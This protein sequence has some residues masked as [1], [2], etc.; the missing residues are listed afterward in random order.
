MPFSSEALREFEIWKRNASKEAIDHVY[1]LVRLIQRFD[2][3]PAE[4]WTVDEL[5]RF[6]LDS[7]AE[8][9][10]PAEDSAIAIKARCQLARGIRMSLRYT[11]AIARGKAFPH[12][13]VAPQSE[14]N[15][16]MDEAVEA[17]HAL[18]ESGALSLHDARG[19]TYK[20][21]A[22]IFSKGPLK[23]PPPSDEILGSLPA[24]GPSLN[25]PE[26]PTLGRLC[27]NAELICDG[28]LEI[29]GRW[30]NFK[31]ELLNNLGST[32]EAR[33]K[34]FSIPRWLPDDTV[35]GVIFHALGSDP[36]SLCRQVKGNEFQIPIWTPCAIDG[37]QTL[38]HPSDFQRIFNWTVDNLR[39]Q[40]ASDDPFA[41]NFLKLV[42][43]KDQ[44]H[45][46]LED[47]VK[48]WKGRCAKL[49]N[50]SPGRLITAV[51][52]IL[53][54]NADFEIVRDF[55]FFFKAST[56]ELFVDSKLNYKYDLAS[57]ASLRKAFKDTQR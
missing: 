42:S 3:P 46:K 8:I 48:K 52:P 53:G 50:V 17:L 10:I 35:D 15:A 9:P 21:L 18:V 31:S 27:R 22:D 16:S 2:G 40:A 12:D 32:I 36:M 33:R 34:A 20:G 26:W 7:L 57:G 25:L 6:G 47:F 4:W 14:K 24:F 28:K 1:Y 56:G 23:V 5:S 30:G 45:G 51:R 55:M 13:E 39:E 44:F 49:G 19:I 43:D 41:K 37:E 54:E 11:E 29:G 38:I